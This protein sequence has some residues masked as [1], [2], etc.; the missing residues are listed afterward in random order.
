MLSAIQTRFK[1]LKREHIIASCK[2]RPVFDFQQTGKIGRPM[3]I[4]RYNYRAKSVFRLLNASCTFQC[5]YV[6]GVFARRFLGHPGISTAAFFES[7]FLREPPEADNILL[8]FLL[9]FSDLA[10]SLATLFFFLLFY[11]TLRRKMKKGKGKVL[12]YGI[13][14]GVFTLISYFIIPYAADRTADDLYIVDFIF[15]RGCAFMFFLFFYL[16]LLICSYTE[17]PFTESAVVESAFLP[18]E[19]ACVLVGSYA[20]TELFYGKVGSGN[21]FEVSNDSDRRGSVAKR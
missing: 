21:A 17:Y 4:K 11:F 14:L 6:L 13:L 1:I 8:S 12:C 7:G 9:N 10:G 5:I 3:R 19:R 15:L 18:T 16:I 20:G 2:K